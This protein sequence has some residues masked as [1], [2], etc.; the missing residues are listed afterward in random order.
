MLRLEE[1][2][3]RVNSSG[4]LA[5]SVPLHTY[6]SLHISEVQS[7]SAKSSLVRGLISVGDVHTA[8]SGYIQLNTY[9]SVVSSTV[10]LHHSYAF[11]A[12]STTSHPR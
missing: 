3:R 4:H 11:I 2:T 5:T 12:Q 1:L 10:I 6:S 9:H 7:I 8:A